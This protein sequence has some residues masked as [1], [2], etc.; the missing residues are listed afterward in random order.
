MTKK[1]L[2]RRIREKQFGGLF[3]QF[4]DNWLKGAVS[5]EVI[6]EASG[7][8]LFFLKSVKCQP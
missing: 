4:V 2:A 6:L 7:G 8:H 3:R 5:E 1:R